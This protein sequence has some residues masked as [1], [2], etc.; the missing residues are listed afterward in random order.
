[1]PKKAEHNVQKAAV[2]DLKKTT[3]KSAKEGTKT[4]VTFSRHDKRNG[5]GGRSLKV[6]TQNG[7][8]SMPTQALMERM[9]GTQDSRY[10]GWAWFRAAIGHYRL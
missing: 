10:R 3:D 7:S 6:A 1:M 2:I 8:V 5:C 4:I 9:G